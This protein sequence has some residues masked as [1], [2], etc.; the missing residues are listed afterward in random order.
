[1]AGLEHKRLQRRD[2]GEEG[3]GWRRP[4]RHPFLSALAPIAAV[5]VVTGTNR[6]AKGEKQ[7]K[8]EPAREH[9]V[10]S[11]VLGL[12]CAGRDQP[13][14]CGAGAAGEISRRAFGSQVEPRQVSA[15]ARS[16]RWLSIDLT[17]VDEA[18]TMRPRLSASGGLDPPVKTQLPA[19]EVLRSEEHT[20]E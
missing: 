10:P 15:P 1:L 11:V 16:P 7:Q 20:S 2:R 17:T 6:Q 9:R 3:R 12:C 5:A 14:R 19:P 8:Q 4:G 18:T 13:P